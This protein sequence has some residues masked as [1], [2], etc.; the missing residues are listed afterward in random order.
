MAEVEEE[1]VYLNES[2]LE[3]HDF[4]IVLKQHIKKKQSA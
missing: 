3:Q 1:N 4:E 2:S